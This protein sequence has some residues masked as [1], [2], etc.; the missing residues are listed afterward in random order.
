MK[1][2]FSL[3]L[4]QFVCTVAV[5]A[6]YSTSFVVQGDADKYY[7]VVF[8]DQQWGNN[9]ATEF[10]IGRSNVHTDANWRGS[11]IARFRYHVT[12][13]GHGSNFI[14]ANIREA[15]NSFIAGWTD[16][17]A[18]NG[19]AVIIIWLKGGSNTFYVNAQAT[20]SPT[21]YDGVQNALPYQETN[22]PARTYKTAVDPY[23]NSYGE[24]AGNTA[25]YNGGG[26]NYYAG[27]VGIGTVNPNGYK[28]A[29]QGNIH[30]QQVTVDI[31]NWPD[32]VFKP[33]YHLPA[34]T[35]IKTYI[36]QNQHLPGLPS[37]QELAKDGLDLGE[38]NKL[39]AKKIEELTLYLIEQK[40]RTDKLQQQ[41]DKLT[42]N[43]N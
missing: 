8:W 5:M 28:L 29:V 43:K 37:V 40:A 19:N 14:D 15:Y 1:K 2:C 4:M 27:S 32:Y 38:M 36:V 18:L 20:V 7:P 10:D 25:Y 12:N 31:T 35:D 23:V 9:K 3:L 21:V 6:Q 16:A 17:T 42:N 13:Y 24:S 26:N 33:T 11:M 30:A 41:V 39:L 34:L 22:G